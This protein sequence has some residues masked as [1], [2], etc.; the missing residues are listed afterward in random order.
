M[1]PHDIEEK[2]LNHQADLDAERS[3][4]ERNALG[5]FATPPDLAEEIVRLAVSHLPVTGPI[6]FLDPSIGS[7]SFYS[8]L[9]RT[10]PRERIAA[11]AG[12]ELDSRFVAT[13][14]QLW[15]RFG[16]EVTAGDFTLLEPPPEAQ[17][18]NLLIANPP[19]VRH[20]H[21]SGEEKTRLKRLVKKRLGI[22]VSGLAGLYVYFLLL[23]LEWMAEGGVAAWLIPSEWADVNYGRAIKRFLTEH[24][25]LLR[26]HIY[27]AADVQ[28]EDA[29]V[30]SSV[31]VF[32]KAD[33]AADTMVQLSAGAD[34]DQPRVQKAVHLR[35]ISAAAKWSHAIRQGE[36]PGHRQRGVTVGDLFKIRRGIATGLN[37]FFI[38]P[39]SEWD[40][41]GIPREVLRPV[42]PPGRVMK[43]TVIATRPDGY[44]DLSDP[45]G[46]LDCRLPEEEVRS[47]YPKLWDY[48][49]QP[50]ADEARNTYLARSRKSWYAQESREPSRY[51]STY[52]GRGSKGGSPFRIFLNRSQ[53]IATNGYIMLYPQGE[54]AAH[55]VAHP[56][57]EEQVL[58]L[59]TEIAAGGFQQHGR[60]Y[61][62]G[63]HKLEPKELAAL[64]ADVLVGA[65]S[66]GPPLDLQV[67]LGL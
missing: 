66:L 26:V 61:G 62:G 38:R 6:R 21:L 11:A 12:V 7:G 15:G 43:S 13:A 8:A 25:T 30:S 40:E 53:A 54:L 35:D 16:L 24:A 46:L 63:L 29:L 19:Y 14:R 27:E 48:L 31:L 51:V 37:P 59:L 65:L 32:R 67:R 9:L 56:E 33:P 3:A 4:A 47:K 58:Q 57:A 20:H 28:F 39:L 22:E 2:R 17:R 52:M 36:A 64:P 45:L 5:Q 44:P 55:L 60:V 34:L 50:Q 49:Q 41:L 23:S 18:P 10:V 42:L 1:T